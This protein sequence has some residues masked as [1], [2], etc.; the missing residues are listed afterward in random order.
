MNGD[1]LAPST[2]P[3]GYDLQ[4]RHL[5]DR[6]VRMGN[7]ALQMVHDGWRAFDQGDRRLAQSNLDRNAMLDQMDDEMEHAA[8]AFLVLR[9]PT[10]IDLRT[11]VGLLKIT[12]HLDRVGRLGYDMS[13]ITTPLVGP[14]ESPELRVLLQRMDDTVESMVRQA[15]EGLD[16]SR[17]DLARDLFRRDDEVDRMHREAQRIVVVELGRKSPPTARLANIILVA[18]H[19]ERIADNACKVAEKTIYAITG[20]RR[21]EYLPRRSPRMLYDDSQDAGAPM[22]LPGGGPAPEA[23]AGSPPP[24]G[25]GSA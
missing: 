7:W 3:R 6:A 14:R 11:A 10:A 18:R 15:L 12:T 4:V 5:T 21:T 2:E 8:I 13:R 20:Q 19:F 16:H 23:G 25:T 22:S 9:Q 24:T 17:V 1:P